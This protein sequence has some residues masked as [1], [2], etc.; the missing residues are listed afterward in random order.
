[1]LTPPANQSYREG[2]IYDLCAMLAPMAEI[3]FPKKVR[4]AYFLDLLVQFRNKKVGHGSLT[5]PEA[6]KIVVELESALIEWLAGLETIQHNHLVYI[7]QVAWM[8]DHFVYDG[9]DLTAGSSIYP[10][11]LKGRVGLNRDRL[12]LTQS[13][14]AEYPTLIP[15]HP[16]FVFDLETNSLYVYN[17]ISKKGNLILR[18]PYRN[19]SL[20]LEEDTSLVLGQPI[21]TPTDARIETE[22]TITA[23]ESPTIPPVSKEYTSMKSWYDIIPPHEDIRKGDFDE[24]IFAADLGDVAA[25]NAPPDYR[26]PYLFFK[27]TYPTQGL[28]NLLTRVQQTLT[29]GK[30]L[31]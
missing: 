8:D 30:G 16:F 19:A 9:V 31:R 6:Q 27:K 1:M 29:T 13:G 18:C 14:D 20:A 23:G 26:D 5:N 21:P 15:L 28:Q 25:G 12:Y 11:R 4:I 24:A 17:E 2:D 3:E 7:R 10:A 22:E